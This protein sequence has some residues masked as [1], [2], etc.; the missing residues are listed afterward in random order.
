MALLER[1]HALASLAEYADSAA[2]GDGRVVLI[3]GE[4][5]VGKSTL[6][7]HFETLTGNARWLH[8]A[9]DGLFT[10]RP[11]GPLF[12]IAEELGGE[13]L[14]ACRRDD[15]RDELFRR[16]LGALSAADQPRVVLFE[17]V[18]WADASTLDLIRFLGRRIRDLPVLL[19]VTYRDDELAAD[20]PLRLVLGELAGL[21]PTR[22]IDLAPLSP[23]A[24]RDLASDTDVDAEELYRLSGG[25]P[26][27][28]TEV[29]QTG[30]AELPP[31]AR[32]AVLARLARLSADAR[33]V[34]EAAALIGTHVEHEL[35]AAVAAATGG[36]LDELVTSGLVRTDGGALRFRHELSRLAVEGQTA[37]HRRTETHAR[38]L[39]ALRAGGCEDDARLAHHAEGAGDAPA[40]LE[41]APRAARR[42][43]DLGA[44]RQAA[45]QYERAL[46]FT[47][48]LAEPGTLAELNDRLAREQAMFDSWEQARI[49][50]ER[51]LQLWRQLDDRQCEGSTMVALSKTMF[52]LCRGADARAYAKSAVALLE[53]AG[54]SPALAEAYH[55][56]ATLTNDLVLERK[57]RALA[58]QLHLPAVL[59]DALNSEACMLADEDGDWEPVMRRALD[60]ALA[61]HAES[62]AGRAY[63][64]LHALLTTYRRFTDADDVFT[65]GMAYC[66][67]HDLS[68]NGYCLAGGQADVLVMRTR[69][70]EA[71]ALCRPLLDSEGP[72]PSNRMTLSLHMGRA[73]TRRGDPQG[74]PVLDEA[75]DNATTIDLP[76]WLLE[77]YPAHAEAHWLDG[78]LD[79]AIRDLEV[80]ARH[81]DAGDWWIAGSVLTWCR[82]L[83]MDVPERAGKVAE[84]YALSLGSDFTAA[85]R[86]WDEL[87]CP[88]DAALAYYDSGT[89]DGLREAIRRFEAVGATAAVEA[90]R[91]EMRR[92]G[93]RSVPAGARSSTRAHPLGLTR[94]EAE[95][96][97]GVCAGRTN[98]EI[99]AQLFLSPRTVDHHVSSLLAKLGVSSRTEAA[100]EATRRGLVSAT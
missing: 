55:S 77:V 35:L 60:I 5:G 79:A 19:L 75:Y 39:A 53:P 8:G 63:S 45:A 22:R 73:L 100:A 66:Q 26:F 20:H 85:A 51:A 32:D 34:A 37:P 99:S 88:Y 70:D 76:G 74:R 29:L 65:E 44:H 68:T 25:N 78:D 49:A 27:F 9:C 71:V 4:S 69:W 54:A 24:V 18:H 30:T 98:A 21:R 67:D 46:R 89:E 31:S 12:D 43:A 36:H 94:R 23:A 97:E 10:P 81:L 72:S 91:R 15:P 48:G 90:A 16:L 50:A 92:R 87:G 33:Q 47:A 62:Q 3:S 13:L 7:E 82:R 1:D 38:V 58:E 80:A 84:P 17:D 42:A 86:A 57:A 28:V 83:G 40:V 59:S 6:V 96:L 2:T 14:A 61:A 93:M 95:V 52:R 56:L 64:N 11:L 41:F